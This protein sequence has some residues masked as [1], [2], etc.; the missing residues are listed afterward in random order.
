MGPEMGR[1]RGKRGRGKIKGKGHAGVWGQRG[2]GTEVRREGAN[3]CR[4]LF[5]N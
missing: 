2:G 5:L 3:M 1:D 4:I